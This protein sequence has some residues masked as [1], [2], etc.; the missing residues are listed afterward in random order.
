MIT[1]KAGHFILEWASQV[2]PRVYNLIPCEA[3]KYIYVCLSSSDRHGSVRRTGTDNEP[4][5]ASIGALFNRP[6]HIRRQTTLRAEGALQHCW[7]VLALNACTYLGTVRL[8]IHT[9]LLDKAF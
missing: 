5:V 2:Q 6:I 1:V 7:C 3:L 8:S 4:A 9:E